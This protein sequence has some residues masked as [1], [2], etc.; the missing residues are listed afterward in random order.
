MSLVSVRDGSVE[1]ETRHILRHSLPPRKLLTRAIALGVLNGLCAVALL[2]L[3]AWLITR[4]SEQPSIIYLSA[5]IVGVRAFALGGAFFRYLERLASHD[6]AFRQLGEVRAGMFKRL[7]PLAPAGLG[8]VNSGDVLSRFASD[9]DDLQ[10]YPLRV[11]QPLIT[12]SV[13]AATAITGVAL[14]LPLAAVVLALALLLALSIGVLVTR[15]ALSDTERSIAPL[16]SALVTEI[17]GLVRKLDVLIAFDALEEAQ[18]RVA[19]ASD[20]LTRAVRVRATVSAIATAGVSVCTGFAIVGVLFV[21]I[22]ALGSHQLT[23]PQLAALALL[24]LA[25]FEFCGP[26]PVALGVYHRVRS[27]AERIATTAPLALPAE[28]VVDAPD[29]K[30]VDITTTPRI[31]LDVLVARWPGATLPALREVSLELSPGERV[32]LT[33]PTGSG[34]TTLAYVLTRLLDMTGS[35]TINGVDVRELTQDCVRKTVSLCE[36]HPYLFD[37]T[38][39]QNILFARDTATDHELLDVVDRVGLGQWVRDRGGLDAHV[40]ERGA[41]VS[42][43]QAQRI[44]VARMLL[45]SVPIMIFDEPTAHVDPGVADRI[46]RDLLSLA[47]DEGRTALLISH[48]GA[49]AE[50]ITRTVTMAEG[51]LIAG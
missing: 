30:T 12:A 28:I 47:R 40:G 22:P 19:T 24:P 3:S 36:Q 48:T 51:R 46:V 35:Y 38:I 7:I 29:A 14:F 42:G 33:G 31:R 21:G 39:R 17:V 9:V 26:V 49:P 4:A 43:G 8:A 5:A 50:L 37:S 10:D 44:A 1:S 11:I 32:L 27:S 13:V 23:A 18:H 45:S 25:L 20:A 6:A 16:R 15:W 34:K 41:L 2:V